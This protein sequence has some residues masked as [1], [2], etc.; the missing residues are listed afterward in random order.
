MAGKYDGRTIADDMVDGCTGIVDRETAV[1]AVRVI[2]RYFGGTIIYIP[3]R[4][5]NGISAKELRGV[6]IDAVGDKDG[7]RILEKIM[8]LLGGQQLYIPMENKAFREEIALEIYER[9]D[10]QKKRSRDLALEYRTSSNQIYQLW[11]LGRKI[12]VSRREEY[13]HK[14]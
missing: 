5:V 12:K 2:C 7:E 3:V 1:K 9:F 4:A 11:K 6:L 10:G 8:A 13:D 14:K